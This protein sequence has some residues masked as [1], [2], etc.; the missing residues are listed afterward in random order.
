VATRSY[1]AIV[2]GAGHNGLVAAGLLARAGLSTLVLERADRIGGAVATAEI[3]PGVRVPA[4]AH[5]VG[6]LRR[7]VIRDLGLHHHGLHLIRQN[8][9]AFAP[10]PDGRAITLWSDVERTV[11][12]LR[13]LSAA[14]AEAYE[15]FDDLIAD[16][17]EEEAEEAA[18]ARESYESFDD[19]VADDDEESEAQPAAEPPAAEPAPEA[20][21]EAELVDGAPEP[22][23]P[24]PREP[25]PTA[26]R[27]RKVS[28]V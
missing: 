10:L 7:S 2:V 1:D 16:T 22:P 5:T 13:A 18:P 11:E 3:A 15:S 8:A 25:S 17:S 26:R 20:E 6:R 28:F 12:G 14:D 24:E 19:V 23:Q 27:R 9:R 21:A 4:L